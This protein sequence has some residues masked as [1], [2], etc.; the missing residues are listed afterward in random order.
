MTLY[1]TREKHL[2]AAVNTL[3]TKDPYGYFGSII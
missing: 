3:K 1:V 2:N